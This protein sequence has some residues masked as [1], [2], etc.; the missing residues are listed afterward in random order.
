[1]IKKSLSLSVKITSMISIL[2]MLTIISLFIWVSI[3]PRSLNFMSPYVEEE[4]K[5]INPKIDVKIESSFIQ[6]D[7]KKRAITL[8]AKNINVLNETKDTIAN[9]PEISFGFSILKLFKGQILSSD[10]TIIKPSFHLNTYNKTLYVTPESNNAFQGMVFNSLYDII[11]KSHYSFNI[12]SI[13]IEQ[14]DIFISTTSSDM[15]WQ[16]NDGYAKLEKGNNG[17]IIKSEFNINFG[18]DEAYFA[19]NIGRNSDKSI[20]ISMNFK[21]LPSYTFSDIFPEYNTEQKINMVLTGT[22][23]A[24]ITENGTISQSDIKIA[25]AYGDVDFPE[26]FNNPLNFE[27]LKIDASLYDNFSQLTI[28]NIEG[29]LHGTYI[30]ISGN[31]K[32]TK[33]WPEFFPSLDVNAQINNLEINELDAYWPY[34]FGHEARDWVINNIKD[35][36]VPHAEGRFI[37]SAEDIQNIIT[38]EKAE[39]KPSTPP[40]P[41]EAIN[42]SITLE[43]ANLTYY[44]NYPEIKDIKSV[45]KFS[46]HGMEANIESAKV[47]DSNISNS[48]VKFPN[49]WEHPLTIEIESAFNG[50]SEDLIN[51]LKTSHTKNNNQIMQ[52]IYKAQGLAEGKIYLSIP[53]KKDLVYDDISLKILSNLK[54]T[55]I[56]GLVN[57]KDITCDN[58]ILNLDKY[59]LSA[60][61]DVTIDKIPTNI[62]VTKDLSPSANPENI[63][64]KLIGSFE[65]KEIKQLS[66]V[67]LGFING[68]IGIN[69]ETIIENNNTKI[70]G[71]ANLSTAEIVI[72]KFGN[73]KL[74]GGRSLANFNIEKTNDTLDI[75]EF[76]LTD[77]NTE[78]KGHAKLKVDLSEVLSF[79]LSQAKFDNNDFTLEYETTDKGVNLDIKG[80]SLDLSHAQIGELFKQDNNTSHSFNLSVDLKNVYMRNSEVF[81]E[82]SA[83]MQCDSKL[84]TKGN[85][86]TKINNDNF[87]VMSLKNIGDRS[88]LL[89][90]SDNAGAVINAFNISRNIRGGQLNIDA[91][92]NPGKKITIARGMIK[93]FDFAAVKTPLLGKILTLASFQGFVDLLNNEGISF[94]K[95]EAPITMG[96]GIITIKNAKSSGSSIGLTAEGTINTAQDRVDIKGVIVPAYA[97]NKAIGKIPL[98]G[99][100]IIGGK[101]EGILATKYSLEGSYDDAKVSVNPL[102]ILTPGFLRNIFDVF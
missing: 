81:K 58:I 82:L 70:S 84:C 19:A 71:S 62:E 15:L 14:A 20:D 85:L 76:N 55:S 21:D 79:N 77:D 30:K 74:S 27:T 102:S 53:I 33:T 34:N 46:G 36:L 25:N 66:G 5:K 45:V 10:L 64:Y 40:I 38:R 96:D 43:K 31:V 63:K 48:V 7:K 12:S 50:K 99:N 68:K 57:G 98:V 59:L 60:K 22:V 87:L 3:E 37:F 101:N 13:R 29:D 61:G 2:T 9:L 83:N 1:M 32:N 56:P 41:E 93:I 94:K 51:F 67:D 8:H 16:I 88:S 78:I 26:L 65:P 100:I 6:F 24:L 80:A 97:V 23:R 44:H 47:L 39:T 28:N 91:T 49:L 17:N 18:N 52:N 35:G 73:K 69:I 72:P 42:A 92:L 90:E 11:S 54:N 95:F 75:K 4:L 89:V 86:Y